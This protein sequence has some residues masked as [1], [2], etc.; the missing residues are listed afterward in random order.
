MLGGYLER[1]GNI[2]GRT[3][4]PEIYTNKTK[5]NLFACFRMDD[6]ALYG[7]ASYFGHTGV[8]FDVENDRPGPGSFQDHFEAT[9]GCFLRLKAL[10]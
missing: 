2:Y 5:R 4:R 10:F 1:H 6:H 3:L 7:M 9:R 8:T